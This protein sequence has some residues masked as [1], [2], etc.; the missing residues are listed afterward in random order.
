MDAIV[1]EIDSAIAKN[2]A[3]VCK[4]IEKYI[5]LLSKIRYINIIVNKGYLHA[6]SS[7][8]FF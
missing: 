8:S 3:L 6:S 5:G 7:L 4:I 1:S 2:V